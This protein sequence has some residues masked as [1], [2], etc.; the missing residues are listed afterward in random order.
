MNLSQ[1]ILILLT[2]KFIILLTLCVTV[3]TTT[4]VSLAMPKTYT[5]SASILIDFKGADP[6][7]GLVLPAQLLPGYMATQVD[8]IASHNVALRV[9][10]RLKLDK[11]PVVIEKFN[12]ATEGKGKIRD[13][14][15][16]IL[17][18]DLEVK[19]SK[20]SSVINI[21][22][23]GK[24]PQFAAEMA[25]AFVW[26]Y[27]QVNLDLR[28]EPARQQSAWFDEQI[29][30][31][32][33]KMEEAQKRLSDYQRETGIMPLDGRLDVEHVRL[34]ELSSQ[35]V[36]AHTQTYDSVTRQRQI[37]G[38]HAKGKLDELPE[39]LGN[40]LV[41]SLKAEL[42]KAESKL[43]EASGRVDKNHPHYVSALAE[44]ES[45][46]HKIATEIQTARGSM[47]NVAVQAQQRE[48]EL[49]KALAEQKAHV[50]ELKQQRDRSDLLT[51]EVAS[52]QAALDSSTQ[53]ANL[54]RLESQR[55]LTDIAV[56]NPAIAPIKHSK[57]KI[58]LNI[59]LAM[60]FGTLLGVGFG[61]LSEMTDRRVR[62]AEEI[63]EI[64]GLPVLATVMFSSPRRTAK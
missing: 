32:R 57:P 39:I 51:Q 50:L 9:I 38:A 20:E 41:Q 10:D 29:K 27:T 15:A 18:K 30:G 56:L 12:E 63:S 54:I 47:E 64:L 48:N 44:V 17:L 35:L 52:A 14:L 40:N 28:L 2:R 42:A 7:T 26:A 31:L 37:S 4:I 22:F 61:F 33:T 24:E 13:W 8:I 45:L 21:E 3:A 36:A 59:A 34:G 49:K 58:L 19:P 62:S 11:L 16:D 1:F 5:G 46:K 53:R 55:D 43:A 23:S 25:N 60:F 6:V